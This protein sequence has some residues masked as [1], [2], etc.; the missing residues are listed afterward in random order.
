MDPIFVGV[1]LGYL[2]FGM[3]GCGAVLACVVPG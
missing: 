1:V 3:S 2:G